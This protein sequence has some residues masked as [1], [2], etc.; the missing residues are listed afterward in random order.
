MTNASRASGF[1]LEK[2]G[3]IQLGNSPIAN[4]AGASQ[5]YECQAI[6][7]NFLAINVPPCS[8]VIGRATTRCNMQIIRRPHAR[9]IFI[10]ILLFL[11]LFY[12]HII[13]IHILR[14]KQ[15]NQVCVSCIYFINI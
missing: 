12:T 9:K 10:N 3:D 5:T 15:I 1:P 6:D 4:R 13:Y 14:Y 7:Q 8:F 2:L 11:V